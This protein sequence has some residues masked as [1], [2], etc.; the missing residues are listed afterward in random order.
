MLKLKSR[1]G[2][3]AAL[4]TLGLVIVGTLITLGTSFFVNKT[5]NL[6][7]NPKATCGATQQLCSTVDPSYSVGYYY[8]S[9]GKY[10]SDSSCSNEIGVNPGVGNYCENLQSSGSLSPPSA[11]CTADQIT[12]DTG[13]R[14]G[15]TFSYSYSTA[16]VCANESSRNSNKCFGTQSNCVQYTWTEY[17]NKTCGISSEAPPEDPPEAGSCAATSS[18][19]VPCPNLACCFYKDGKATVYAKAKARVNNEMSTP[20]TT[21]AYGDAYGAESWGY[22]N[23]DG[24]GYGGGGG[25]GGGA[26]ATGGCK[27]DKL[28]CDS[29]N[30]FSYSY[31][32][33]GACASEST[34]DT[35]KCYGTQ[36]NCNQFT[37]DEFYAS[38][39]GKSKTTT[40][41]TDPTC[42]AVDMTCNTG[43][44]A[45]S[46]FTYSQSTVGECAGTIGLNSSKC[47]GT[48]SDCTQYTWNEYYN[49]TCGVSSER[50]AEE[51][52]QNSMV[53]Y[54]GANSGKTYQYYQSTVG[55]CASTIGTNTSKCFGTKS[56]CDQYTWNEYYNQTC[57][58]SS[59]GLGVVPAACI[60][61]RISG[62]DYYT[63]PYDPNGGCYWYLF[64]NCPGYVDDVPYCFSMPR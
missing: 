17:E 5:K 1:K 54:T 29:G 38:K 50:A 9:G 7:S 57:G 45:G 30:I 21:E 35:N 48:K 40:T 59:G 36:S 46:T 20:C 32:T 42:A 61:T 33:A 22:C 41:T 18:N 6:A 12:C 13:T 60:A 15:S 49:Q 25:G 53:C 58:V 19:G 10:Y 47:F 4:L 23:D 34:R 39:C 8:A 55:E 52:T 44:R 11:S 28:A 51:C 27:D 14:E 2:E 24:S 3:V 37:Y 43:S 62:V 31:S 56:D 16:G 63:D 26:A 64:K